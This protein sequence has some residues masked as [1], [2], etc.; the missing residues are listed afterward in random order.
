[1]ATVTQVD[2]NSI[3]LQRQS[4]NRDRKLH[5][6]NDAGLMATALRH[7]V[8]ALQQLLPRSERLHQ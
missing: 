5:Q 4:S 6:N 8:T 1:M 2:G 7:E 3:A